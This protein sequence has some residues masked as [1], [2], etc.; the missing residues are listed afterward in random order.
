MDAELSQIFALFELTDAQASRYVEL[1]TEGYLKRADPIVDDS[2]ISAGL[3]ERRPDG[4]AL[5]SLR[6]ALELRAAAMNEK[7][8]PLGALQ[9]KWTPDRTAPPAPCVKWSTVSTR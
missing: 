8:S 3:A 1:R 9:S 6:L 7:W 5:A 2:L 4:I